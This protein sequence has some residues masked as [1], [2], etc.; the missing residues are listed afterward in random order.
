MKLLPKEM[1]DDPILYPAADLLTPLE[2][3]ATATCHQRGPRR[4]DGPLQVGLSAIGFDIG[5][6][7]C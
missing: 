3:G 2:F 4:A 6:S 7:S 1:L 5:A